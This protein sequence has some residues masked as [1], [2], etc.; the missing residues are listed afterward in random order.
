MVEQR[1]EN[2]RVGGSNPPLGTIRERLILKK[3][4]I[5]L[6]IT[7]IFSS[8]ES[9][10]TITS[11]GL[12]S[13][14]E[15]EKAIMQGIALE[16]YYNRV[17]KL[18]NIAWPILSSSLD[19]CKGNITDSIG[20]EVIS[21]NE[22]DKNYK[23]AASEKIG[24]T[25]EPQILYIIKSSPADLSGLNKKDKI[26]E[27]SSSEYTWK[28]DDIVQNTRKRIF[29]KDKI[30]ITVERN[31]E[32]QIFEVNPVKICNHRIIL[33]QDNSLN[34]F[35]DGKN[36]YITQGMLRFIEEDK[37]LQMVIAHELAHNI[38]G[39]IEK[40]TNNYLLG[41]IVDLAAAGAGV[42]TRGTFGSLGA[43]MYSQ[44]FEREA[45]YVGMYILANSGI[46]REG[47]ANFWRRM[48]VENPRS[49]SYASTHPS[50]SE[51][52]VNIEA[53]NKEIDK[54]IRDSEPLLPE[55]IQTK[56]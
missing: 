10:T 16:A 23:N 14:N 53:V 9:P 2:P 47:V 20:I 40:K 11:R 1:T 21:L 56:D 26:I 29:G 42:N 28:G 43:Q 50:S 24:L 49:I 41:T 48:S 12:K 19:F 44:D 5:L 4:F 18:N 36:I 34:A 6:A 39:H 27:I 37:E 13:D 33:R 54:K 46:E 8:C 55:R 45:D 7:L 25:N 15:K 51:R 22:I 31:S 17:E 52:W 30:K 38:E 3:I 32:I 35:A